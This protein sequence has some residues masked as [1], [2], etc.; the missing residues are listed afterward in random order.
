[1]CCNCATIA[2]SIISE[3]SIVCT[4][5]FLYGEHKRS[6]YYLLHILITLAAIVRRYR[7]KERH[8]ESL[9]EGRLSGSWH[10]R[11]LMQV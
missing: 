10:V 2:G 7:L 4:M 11:N 5:K 6:P 9:E 8:R 1:M 3:A